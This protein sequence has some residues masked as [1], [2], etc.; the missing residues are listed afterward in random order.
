M[1]PLLAFF[2]F[3]QGYH[4]MCKGPNHGLSIKIFFVAQGLQCFMFFLFTIIRS[5]AFNGF[6]KLSILSECELHF[7]YGASVIEILLYYVSIGAGAIC[8]FL[9]HKNYGRSEPYLGA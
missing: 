8:L 7:S 2:T 1:W 3:Y 6:A 5:G 4:A 9:A